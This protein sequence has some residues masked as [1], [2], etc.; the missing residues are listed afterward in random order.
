MVAKSPIPVISSMQAA[1]L[2]MPLGADT[3]T[4]STGVLAESEDPLHPE[5]KIANAAIGTKCVIFILYVT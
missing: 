4:W 3:S 5:T 1:S 2:E